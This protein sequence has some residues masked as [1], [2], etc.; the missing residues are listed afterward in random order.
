MRY[1]TTSSLLTFIITSTRYSSRCNGRRWHGNLWHQHTCSRTFELVIFMVVGLLE[2]TLRSSMLISEEYNFICKKNAYFATGICLQQCRRKAILV[3]VWLCMP[4][5]RAA[6]KQL[7][8]SLT[9]RDRMGLLRDAFAFATA[10]ETATIPQ[11]ADNIIRSLELVQYLM[12]AK[13]CVVWCMT[14]N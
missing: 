11:S 3:C 9:T 14:Q 1:V 5:Y 4:M 13:V 6:T 7:A 12:D 2:F 10:P 8:H